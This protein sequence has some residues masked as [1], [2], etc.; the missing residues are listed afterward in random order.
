MVDARRNKW[1]PQPMLLF[2]SKVTP[3]PRTMNNNNNN[4]YINIAI[5]ALL[6]IR[7]RGGRG[8]KW[9]E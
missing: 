4:K 2:E 8:R 3:P 9:H 1:F 5:A 6:F 7:L